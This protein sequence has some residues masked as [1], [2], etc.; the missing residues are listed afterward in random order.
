MALKWTEICQS[1]QQSASQ[2]QK[3]NA[4]SFRLFVYCRIVLEALPYLNISIF[5]NSIKRVIRNH[6]TEKTVLKFSH[7]NSMNHVLE[8]TQGQG[9][10]S[11]Q[12]IQ[13]QHLS[14]LLFLTLYNIFRGYKYSSLLL[15]AVKCNFNILSN[16]KQ[17]D[18]KR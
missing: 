2:L 4:F 8:H 12:R 10:L 6:C 13:F 11:I 9:Q 18:G 17:N 14:N 7:N 5:I 16:L 1:T 3:T 15:Q